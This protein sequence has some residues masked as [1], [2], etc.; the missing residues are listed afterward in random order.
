[1]RPK[2]ATTAR[3]LI[4]VEVPAGVRNLSEGNPDPALLPALAGAFAAAAEEGDREPV[5]Y[6]HAPVEPGLARL[7]RA[8]LDADGVP[9][10]PVAVT[11]GALDA[12]ERV[13]VA[14]LRPGTRSPWR[15]RGGES[16]GSGSGAGAEGGAGGGRRRGAV[17]G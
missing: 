16:A 9:D 4:R 15:I 3:D 8:E 1:M 5:L 10:G 7:A 12:M 17:A 14:H 13:L 11:S 6:G 2:P